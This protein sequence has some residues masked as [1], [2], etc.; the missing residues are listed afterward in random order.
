MGW[1]RGMGE[2][3]VDG[4]PVTEV[5]NQI[6]RIRDLRF[7][8][9]RLFDP[10]FGD[11][12]VDT[13][14]GFSVRQ[15]DSGNDQLMIESVVRDRVIYMEARDIGGCSAINA[16]ISMRGQA[17]DFDTWAQMGNQGWAYEDVAAVLQAHGKL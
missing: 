14:T 16:M 11:F 5:V 15:L 1:L 17:Q 2:L 9:D 12:M 13:L 3:D 6:D 10:R 7:G 8:M 4:S